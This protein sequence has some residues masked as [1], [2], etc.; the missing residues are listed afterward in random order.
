[1]KEINHLSAQPALNIWTELVILCPGI[2]LY[3]TE[4]PK[5]YVNMI[6]ELINW[7]QC[8]D[9][10]WSNSSS[11]EYGAPKEGQV[12]PELVA[13]MKEFFETNITEDSVKTL[14]KVKF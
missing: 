1:M 10:S 2:E 4:N 5:T 12:P 8:K 13:V 9:D 6:H 11:P 3:P 7:L 14:G